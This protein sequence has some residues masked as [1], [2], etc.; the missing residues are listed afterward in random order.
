M[1]QMSLKGG[2]SPQRSSLECWR[3]DQA[4]LT[5]SAIWAPASMAGGWELWGLRGVVQVSRAG[6]FAGRQVAHGVPALCS[7]GSC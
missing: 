2:P 1:S 5:S 3:T 4:R 7:R 6:I